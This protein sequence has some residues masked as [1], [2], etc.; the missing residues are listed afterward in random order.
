MSVTLKDLLIKL[1]TTKEIRWLEIL[2]KGT[3]AE[4]LEYCKLS[5]VNLDKV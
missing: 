2:P 4:K 3:E 1:K 5:G